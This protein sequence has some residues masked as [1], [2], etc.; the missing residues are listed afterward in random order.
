MHEKGYI[1]GDIKPDNV[2]INYKTFLNAFTKVDKLEESEDCKLID[3]GLASKY[4]DD[5]GNH[6]EPRFQ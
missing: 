5:H 2:L 4:I 3:F 1:H 6:I